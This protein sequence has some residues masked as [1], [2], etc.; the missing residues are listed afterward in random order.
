MKSKNLGAQGKRC[1][2]T[3]CWSML[4]LLFLLV[5]VSA[6]TIV[7]SDSYSPPIDYQQ[8]KSAI[9]EMFSGEDL[10]FLTWSCGLGFNPYHVYV[11][12][13]GPGQV[14]DLFNLDEFSFGCDGDL[15]AQAEFTSLDQF[16]SG[17]HLGR[18]AD[19]ESDLVETTTEMLRERLS[20]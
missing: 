12:R 16:L 9:Q 5:L 10:C 14:P 20:Q 15:I 18:L 17:Y 11:Y 13:G 8:W 3:S 19:N 1:I 6:Y 7:T 2:S 4:A